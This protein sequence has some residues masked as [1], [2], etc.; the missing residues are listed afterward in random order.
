MDDIPE[1]EDFRFHVDVEV[2]F[3][4]LDAMGHVNNAVFFTYFELARTGYM[5]ALGHCDPD[6]PS[7]GELYP[8]ILLDVYCRYLA[9]VRL[10]DGLRVYLRTTEV[11]NRSYGF[12]YLVEK[13][14]D[15]IPVA[16]GR[17]TQVYFDYAAQQTL[18][19]PDDF[20]A[21]LGQIE[22]KKLS[23]Q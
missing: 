4:D 8:F 14:S 7:M 20:R 22:G 21:R 1:R 12:E 19:V 2:R 6:T 18:P 5:K 16:T 9:P 17:S 23:V 13:Q 15:Q 10:G 11:K 3:R